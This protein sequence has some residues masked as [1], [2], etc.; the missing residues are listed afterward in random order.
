MEKVHAK[1]KITRHSALAP[2]DTKLRTINA[3]ILMNATT[4]IDLVIAQ[5]FV[6]ILWEVSPAH[7]LQVW[8]EKPSRVKVDVVPLRNVILMRN[9]QI[10]LYAAKENV[11]MLAIKLVE[12]M[13]NVPPKL[14]DPLADVPSK[15]PGILSRN[16]FNWNVRWVMTVLLMRLVLIKNA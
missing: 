12:L 8:W 11:K 15:L 13:Q 7:V 16:V 2:K 3:W 5:P 10:A 4:P 9:A 14:T 1:W 6:K